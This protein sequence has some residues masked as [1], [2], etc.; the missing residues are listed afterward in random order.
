MKTAIYLREPMNDVKT[1][2]W[3]MAKARQYGWEYE[4]FYDRTNKRK[5]RPAK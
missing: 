2:Q 4:L 1:G 3:L 5:T